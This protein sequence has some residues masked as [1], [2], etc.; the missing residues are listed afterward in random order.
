MLVSIV[1]QRAISE[2]KLVELLESTCKDLD[3]H[4][5]SLG[6]AKNQ[7]NLYQMSVNN[8]NEDK[9]KSALKIIY[10]SMH[11]VIN[12]DKSDYASLSLG[13]KDQGQIWLCGQPT[14][15]SQ[16][17]EELKMEGKIVHHVHADEQK[18]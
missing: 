16:L 10:D 8:K 9:V 7:N 3:I 5:Y 14:E 6:N 1:S 18:N 15:I 4:S 13:D 12:I 17:F 11:S 2:E